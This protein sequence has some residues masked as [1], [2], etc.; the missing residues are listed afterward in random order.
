MSMNHALRTIA[1]GAALFATGAVAPTLLT[2][3]TQTANGNS[4]VTVIV[5]DVIVLDYFTSINIGLAG[6]T[7]SHGH[8]A[9]SQANISGSDQAFNGTGALTTSTLSDASSSTLN[10][11]DVTMTV[12]N[13]WAIR[14]FSPTGK[15]TVSVSGPATL[16]K[17]ATAS[18]IGVSK[19]Q[20]MVDGAST[21]TASTSISANLT[22]IQKVDA[23]MGD[24]LMS[25]NFANT[26]LSG[27]YTGTI[28]ITAV[29][30]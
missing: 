19:L 17:P 26:S 27:D 18:T 20:V 22:G 16:T 5:P 29:T 1:L 10:G 21:S 12:R 24:V 25:L 23:T 28:T 14:G 3:A 4:N 6:R 30:M 7:E 15:A 2:A 11:A 8:G 13:V 9:Y